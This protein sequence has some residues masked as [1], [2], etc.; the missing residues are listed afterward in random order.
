MQMGR[1]QKKNAFLWTQDVRVERIWEQ[2]YFH[3]FF[4]QSRDGLTFVY[5][6]LGLFMI[7]QS[8]L[9]QK[10][11]QTP[12]T[13]KAKETKTEGERE[14]WKVLCQQTAGEKKYVASPET[15]WSFCFFFRF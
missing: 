14:N 3:V 6:L 7:L 10:E 9:E 13:K 11:I 12:K 8:K 1:M 15:L 5:H 2:D 4:A